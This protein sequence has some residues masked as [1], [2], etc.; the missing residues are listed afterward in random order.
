MTGHYRFA[1]VAVAVAAFLLGNTGPGHTDTYP[2]PLLQELPNSLRHSWPA[3][4]LG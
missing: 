1:A 2:G 4:H 3:R